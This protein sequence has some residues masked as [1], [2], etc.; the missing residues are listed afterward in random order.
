MGAK[1]L[2]T[3]CFIWVLACGELFKAY[4]FHVSAALSE[5]GVNYIKIHLYLL[6]TVVACWELL[7]VVTA[8]VES[9]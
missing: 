4:Q 6:S 7:S 8:V 2:Q 5:G 3:A 9:S 1:I